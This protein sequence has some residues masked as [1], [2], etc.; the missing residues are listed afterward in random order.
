MNKSTTYW[1]HQRLLRIRRQCHRY[2]SYCV[3][4][5]LYALEVARRQS[6]G[7]W[8]W[9]IGDAFTVSKHAPFT[10]RILESGRKT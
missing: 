7:T 8:R 2:S 4:I 6:N 1:I 10:S 9:L 5:S 3:E